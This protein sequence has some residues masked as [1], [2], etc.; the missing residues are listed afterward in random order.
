MNILK[1]VATFTAGV[2]TGSVILFWIANREMQ[3]TFTNLDEHPANPHPSENVLVVGDPTRTTKQQQTL[4]ARIST[5]DGFCQEIADRSET[6]LR[7][8][9]MEYEY[10]P[11]EID[12]EAVRDYAEMTV[13]RMMELMNDAGLVIVAKPYFLRLKQLEENNYD[14]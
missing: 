13:L 14:E 1:R 5:I 10:H 4:V 8:S 11:S 2:V 6:A 7:A 9:A 12:V 3:K